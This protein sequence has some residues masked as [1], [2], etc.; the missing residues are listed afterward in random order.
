MNSFK[1]TKL[2][3][4]FLIYSI[5]QLKLCLLKF[6]VSY[7]YLLNMLIKAL[8]LHKIEMYEKKTSVSFKNTLK[9]CVVFQQTFRRPYLSRGYGLSFFPIL[10]YIT[11]KLI[12]SSILQKSTIL[13]IYTLISRKTIK[14]QIPLDNVFIHYCVT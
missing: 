9:D 3:A 6:P 13:K 12:T 8:C 14:V 2:E 11:R 10:R 4:C 5:F 1:N 7:E